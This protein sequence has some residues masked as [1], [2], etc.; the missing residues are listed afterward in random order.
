MPRLPLQLWL[1]WH[2]VTMD[3]RFPRQKSRKKRRKLN[4]RVLILEIRISYLIHRLRLECTD[5]NPVLQVTNTV[6]CMLVSRR[7]RGAKNR[8]RRG[9]KRNNSRD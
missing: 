8:G 5:L 7:P 6:G 1:G 3:D 2:G 9:G 4:M